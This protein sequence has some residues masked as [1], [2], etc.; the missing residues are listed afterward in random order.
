MTRIQSVT[1]DC[2][3][4]LITEVIP[5]VRSA[6]LTWL[7]PG[8]SAGDPDDRQGLAPLWAELLLRGAGDRDSRRQADDFD[9]L[10][11]ARSADV[12][13]RFLRVHATLLGDR[14]P[15]VLPLVADMIRRPRFDPESV[16]SA[17]DLALQAIESLKDDPQERAAIAARARHL[18]PPLNRSG[19]G[20]PDALRRITRDDLLH[21]WAQRARPVGSIL[22]VAGALDTADTAR[23]LD[24][25]LAGWSGQAPAI[26][27]RDAAPRGYAHEP[28]ASNQ[29]QILVLHDAPPEPHPDAV[30]EKLVVSVLAGG[31]SG[32]L[33]TEVREKRGL[34]YAVSASYASDRDHGWVSAYV[35]TTPERAQQSLDVILGELIRIN[36]AGITAEE[37][38]RAVVG[39]KSR[40]VFSGESTAARAGALAAD[41]H[42]IGRPRSLDEI[43]AA[44]DAVSLD[45]LNAYAARRR[46]GTP[47][48]QTLGPAPL[49]PPSA[50]GPAPQRAASASR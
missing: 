48:I 8:G 40:L 21:G 20:E 22:A 41:Q 14:L 44:V 23:R 7:V 9:R 25:L 39:M 33:F 36:A 13:T 27:P 2:G 35:G 19:L 16:E 28:D 18:P 11:A 50:P 4:P 42:K 38:G 46:L 43:A 15:G 24:D 47:T 34:C 49:A 17:R 45:A 31:M 30:L 32:R 26:S 10:G 5:G 6:A 29:V 3:M 37:F 1:L 12:G